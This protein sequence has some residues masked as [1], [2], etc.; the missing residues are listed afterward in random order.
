MPLSYNIKLWQ[1]KR[2]QHKFLRADPEYMK[3]EYRFYIFRLK[4]PDMGNEGE[5]QNFRRIFEKVGLKSNKRRYSGPI[6]H[7]VRRPL[8]NRP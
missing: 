1:Q 7:F 8:L 2:F 3:P 5:A 4:V 6:E